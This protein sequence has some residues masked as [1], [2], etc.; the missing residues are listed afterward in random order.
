MLST[1]KLKVNNLQQKD[2]KEQTVACLVVEHIQSARHNLQ[3]H[4][5]R[6]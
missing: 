3:H 2:H 4:L 5:V 6:Q 1:V